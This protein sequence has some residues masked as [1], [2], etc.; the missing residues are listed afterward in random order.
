[1]A[2]S[3]VVLDCWIIGTS[4]VSLVSDSGEDTVEEG[5]DGF[6][7]KSVSALVVPTVVGET[8]RALVSSK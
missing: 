1:M 4:V 5:T 6:R 3:S 8:V 7:E 2:V